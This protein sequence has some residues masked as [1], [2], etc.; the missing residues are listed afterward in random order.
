MALPF[1]CRAGQGC[2]KD[3]SIALTIKSRPSALCQMPKV[4]KSG[5]SVLFGLGQ[6][7]DLVFDH[8][9]RQEGIGPA[10]GGSHHL[11]DN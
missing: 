8:L 11:A 3:L 7:G 2:G 6:G 4:L 5:G 9:F 10:G 1:L